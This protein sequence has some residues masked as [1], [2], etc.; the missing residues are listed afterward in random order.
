MNIGR[1]IAGQAFRRSACDAIIE[2]PSG[3]R[4]TF[5]ELEERTR[6]LANALTERY[7]VVRGDRVAVLST[8]K[9]EFMEAYIAAAR[10]GFI[11]LALNWRLAAPE[12]GRI[13]KDG[14]PKA[15]IADAEFDSGVA[16]L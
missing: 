15:V 6:L 12:L 1:Q 14:R 8:N 3:R 10:A 5:G 11:T 2:M 9:I 16:A 4:R 13:L 7:G